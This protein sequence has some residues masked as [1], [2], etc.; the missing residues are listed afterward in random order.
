MSIGS[1]FYVALIPRGIFT[2]FHI[3]YG[4]VIHKVQIAGHKILMP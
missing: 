2:H 4:S 3:N 1:T